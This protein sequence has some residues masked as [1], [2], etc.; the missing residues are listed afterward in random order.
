MV[1]DQNGIYSVPSNFW[2]AQ[3]G[4]QDLC[5]L[6]CESQVDILS[7]WCWPRTQIDGVLGNLGMGDLIYRLDQIRLMFQCNVVYLEA[8]CIHLSGFDSRY[9]SG[10]SGPKWYKDSPW[11]GF[12]D[13]S[14]KSDAWK[15]W[16]CRNAW[17]YI[18]SPTADIDHE[19]SLGRMLSQCFSQNAKFQNV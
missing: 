11:Q 13:D 9:S 3:F 1:V 2:E 8:I 6:C 17:I 5:C 10:S 19:E 7:W 12:P 18:K 4:G 14:I 15:I 16:K